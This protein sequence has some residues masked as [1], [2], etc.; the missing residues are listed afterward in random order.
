MPPFEYVHSSA[1]R[2]GRRDIIT[3]AIGT[4][5]LRRYMVGNSRGICH[6]PTGIKVGSAVSE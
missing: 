5:I 6:P 4:V 3:V 1:E 2:S